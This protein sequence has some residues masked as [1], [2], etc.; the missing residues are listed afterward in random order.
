MLGDLTIT[1][2]NEGLLLL[3]S[4]IGGATAIGKFYSNSMKKVIKEQS[5]EDEQ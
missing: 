4:I 2:L 3:V 5:L 1:E